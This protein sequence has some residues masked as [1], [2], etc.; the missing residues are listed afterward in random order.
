MTSVLRAA[1]LAVAVL[2][3]GPAFAQTDS[4]SG[5]RLWNPTLPA[6]VSPVSRA[7]RFGGACHDCDLSNRVLPGVR[8]DNGDFSRAKFV[9][10][11][12]VRM[13]AAGST[14][15]EAD[16]SLANLTQSR[17]ADTQCER[18]LFSGAI[19]AR[20]DL[21]RAQLA[22]ADFANA[23]LAG[24]QFVQARLAGAS[25][26]GV[27][28]VRANFLRADLKHASLVYARLEGTDFTQADLQ[29]ARFS[30]ATLTGANFTG[31]RGLTAPQLR[32]ACGDATTR[33]PPGLRLPDCLKG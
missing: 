5:W 4:K 12:L 26:A 10:A 20:A 9:R 29:G 15:N 3:A 17:L 11:F 19:L 28:A 7:H 2:A 6:P 21:S 25:L 32:G 30:G 16:F 23:E 31:V 13:D 14:F 1:I 18:A 33:L 27:K 8:I 22:G 24:A